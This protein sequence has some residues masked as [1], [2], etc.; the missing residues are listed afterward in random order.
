MS[1]LVPCPDCAAPAEWHGVQVLLDDDALRW[2]TEMVCRVCG[3]ATAVCGAGVPGGMRER[4][5]AE[6]G[7]AELR[8]GPSAD[9]VAVMRVLRRTLGIGLGEARA[10]LERG[11]GGTLPETEL[12]AR[13][14]REAGV[15][16]VAVRG[17]AGS[18]PVSRER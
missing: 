18:G 16:A 10:V 11:Y 5:L 14:L 2:D 13:R 4:L 12:L 1:D 15:D 9:R 7:R 17:A 8:L 6:H 3:S